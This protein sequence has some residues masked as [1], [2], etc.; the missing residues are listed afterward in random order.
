MSERAKEPDLPESDAYAGAP[1]PRFAKTLVGHRDAEL[2]LL[3]AYRQG[4]LAHAWLV[5]GRP[6]IGADLPASKRHPGGRY[7]EMADPAG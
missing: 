4:R 2:T 5:G 7:R 6:G 1:H 3:N